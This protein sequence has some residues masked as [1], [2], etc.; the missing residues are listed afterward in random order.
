MNLR[1]ALAVGI[2]AAG[3]LLYSGTADATRGNE[4]HVSTWCSAGIKYDNLSGSTFKIPAPPSG[5]SWTK[6]VLNGGQ[7]GAPAGNVRSFVV[8]PVPAV[9]TVVTRPGAA[10]SNAILCKTRTTT[11]TTT[12]PPSTTQPPTTLPPETTT[13]PET[14]EPPSSTTPETTGPPTTE[15]PPT[16]EA[17][18]TTEEIPTTT[19]EAT[20]PPVVETGPPPVPP[21]P[22]SPATLP[23]TGTETVWIALAAALALGAGGALT[24]AARR[25]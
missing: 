9:G 22:P 10:V 3:L 25:T 23:E 12:E 21:A 19:T 11:T 2:T 15:Q 14:T 5:Y 17:P 20:T 1:T 6:L 16:T 4:N 18:P 7:D 13:P 24:R 8:E